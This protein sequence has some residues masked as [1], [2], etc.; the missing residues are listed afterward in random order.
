[1]GRT[2]TSPQ[3]PLR[4]LNLPQ[5]LLNSTILRPFVPNLDQP[6]DEDLPV[7]HDGT[8]G[9]FASEDVFEGG[10]VGG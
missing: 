4:L 6:I 7:S 3:L 8:E 5:M 10:A 2:L 9:G 1:M